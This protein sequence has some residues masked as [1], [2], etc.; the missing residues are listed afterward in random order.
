MTPTESTVVVPIQGDATLAGLDCDRTLVWLRGEHDLATVSELAA[1]MARAIALDGADLVVDLSQVEFMDGSTVQV[2]E[3]SREFLRSRT[4]SLQLRAPSV[5][6]QLVLD[7]CGLRHLVGLGPVTPKTLRG[8]APALAMLVAVPVADLVP[9]VLGDV[10][11]A[12]AGS[13]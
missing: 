3:R 6:A 4:R 2:L 8:P 10:Y 9:E 1:T 11:P 5:S 12:G 7:L 13:C